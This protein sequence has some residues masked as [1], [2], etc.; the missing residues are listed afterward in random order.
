MQDRPN[1]EPYVWIALGTILCGYL[2]ANFASIWF[3]IVPSVEMFLIFGFVLPSLF[4]VNLWLWGS[5]NR[6]WL[7]SWRAIGSAGTL[8]FVASGTYTVGTVLRIWAEA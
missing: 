4:I 5:K 7:R 8:V 6:R 2:S 1:F 3:P